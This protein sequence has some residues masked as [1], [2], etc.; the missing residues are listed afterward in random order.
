MFV[1]NNIYFFSG[2]GCGNQRGVLGPHDPGLLR[3]HR[4]EQGGTGPQRADQHGQLRPLREMGFLI[5]WFL[6]Q[7]QF[8]IRIF[9]LRNLCTV[10]RMV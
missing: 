9:C 10:E 7:D 1:R 6:S 5:T 8:Y 4:G 2:D 3:E